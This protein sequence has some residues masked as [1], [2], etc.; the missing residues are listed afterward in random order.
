MFRIIHLK[1]NT[2]INQ[3][4]IKPMQ[5]LIKIAFAITVLCFL[6]TNII[7]AEDSVTQTNENKNY[8]RCTKTCLEDPIDITTCNTNDIVKEQIKDSEKN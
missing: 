2:G 4:Y 5:K 3:P 8:E 7:F 6:S 1:T